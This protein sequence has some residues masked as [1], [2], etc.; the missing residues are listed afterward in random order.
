MAENYKL[1]PDY[2]KM[3]TEVI[4][5]FHKSDE[6]NKSKFIDS[7]EYDLVGYH[8]SLG[9]NIRNHFRLWEKPWTPE[10][11]KIT[12]CDISPHHPDQISMTV[13][14]E[15]HKRLNDERLPR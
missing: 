7:S 5:W 1:I 12:N 2:E 3:V 6:S 8:G 4:D 14:K 10:I 9:K 15:V 11:C 13:I